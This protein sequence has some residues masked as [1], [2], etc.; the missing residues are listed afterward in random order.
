[1]VTN[2]STNQAAET[3]TPTAPEAVERAFDAAQRLLVER[4]E[5]ARLDLQKALAG[6]V[7]TA[8]VAAILALTAWATFIAAVAMGLQMVMPPA[9][10]LAATAGIQVAIALIVIATARARSKKET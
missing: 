7:R 6:M 10:A 3:D 9:A 5:L 8:L 2:G 4:L 1:M